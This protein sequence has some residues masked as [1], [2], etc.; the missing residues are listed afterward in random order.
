MYVDMILPLALQKLYTY[1]V[2]KQ[3]EGSVKEFVRVLVQFGKKKFY[4][5]IVVN[6][7][8]D[9]PDYPTKEITEVIDTEP[10][11]T[12]EQYR[13]W[14]WIADY[15]VCTLGEVMKAAMPAG[16]KLES[17]SKVYA[18]DDFADDNSLTR[19]Q[20]EVLAVVRQHKGCTIT[21]I[22]AELDGTNPIGVVKTLIEK[23]AI[24]TGEQLKDGYKPKTETVYALSPEYRE[25]GALA[26][27]IT[28]VEKKAPRQLEALLTMM[29]AAGGMGRLTSGARIE[30]AKLLQQ[31]KAIAGALG[32][33]VL[34]GVLAQESVNV[35]RLDATEATADKPLE[36]TDAQQKALTEIKDGFA[37]HKPVLLNGVTG[38]G[39]TEIYIHLILDC[40]ARGKNVLYLLPEI[41]L[42]TQIMVR[43]RRFIGDRM[44]VYHS[45]F[46]DGERVEV[47]QKVLENSEPRLILGVRSSILLPITNVGL[48]V[49][50][51]EHESSYKQFDPAPR[52]NARDMAL[53]IGQM[54]KA[55]VLL[56]SATPSL[57]SFANAQS[58][59][60][61]GVA[62]TV[63][64][65]GVQLPNIEIVDM[66]TERKHKTVD[67]IFS[68]RLR[69]AIAQ[70]LDRKEQVILFQNRRGFAPV[71][72]CN[73]C[74]FVPKCVNCDVSLTYHKNVNQL[75]CHYCGYTVGL[76]NLCPACGTPSLRP[77]GF[78]TEKIE[79]ECKR[80]FPAA[81]LVR[82]DLDTAKSRKAYEQIFT[83]FSA[84]KYDILVGTQMVSKGLDFEKVTLV[85][86]MNADSMLNIPDFRAD[87][88]SF[89]MLQQVSGRAGR[90]GDRQGTVVIQTAKPT[91]PVVADVV[92]HD[93]DKSS[94]RLL[95]ERNAYHFP[96]YYRMIN[97]LVKHVEPHVCGEAAMALAMSLRSVFGGSVGG[98]FQPYITRISNFYLQE[99]SLRVPKSAQ[100][101]QVK[102][103]LMQHV[104]SLL[105]DPRYR[106][107][108]VRVDV[109]PY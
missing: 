27:F 76:P 13:L 4:A 43:L 49:V 59:R 37:G 5:G 65:A 104:N 107:A 1:E 96:P 53:V 31:S 91:H 67:G 108:L 18:C 14:Q 102:L 22:A 26:D 89:Q 92:A 6:I 98:P 17:E 69:E 82:M 99:I 58:G 16:L 74:A 39:K 100:P 85:G 41:A 73:Q 103:I 57:E 46:T 106:S 12:P 95:A 79:E 90:H 40:L 32:D 93:Y 30:R 3:L 71:I 51:E 84:G 50:D 33:L 44:L 52:Y 47:W 9:K 56:G 94:Q 64:H 87:E 68:F 48:I 28:T 19:R 54:Q 72:E 8:D 63:R 60:Y 62:L 29:Q 2:P 24:Y 21:E 36:L 78:G 15:Y 80:V 70:A 101:S 55:D 61:A 11:L 83:D 109:D 88:R 42:T 86:V 45:K 77:Q 20:A 66:T 81:R 25:E 35:S 10:I 23:E 38:S 34:K 105:A 75:V 7:H 97:L